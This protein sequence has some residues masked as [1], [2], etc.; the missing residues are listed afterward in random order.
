MKRRLADRR[1]AIGECGENSPDVEAVVQ[2]FW[3][4]DAA[5]RVKTEQTSHEYRAGKETKAGATRQ[6]P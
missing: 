5:A 4:Y 1:K 2:E 6:N 3:N